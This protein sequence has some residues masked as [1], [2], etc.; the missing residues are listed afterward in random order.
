VNASVPVADASHI[1]YVY[2]ASEYAISPMA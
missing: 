1:T 2:S